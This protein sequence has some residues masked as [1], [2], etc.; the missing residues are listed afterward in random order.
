[1]ETEEEIIKAKELAVEYIK[2]LNQDLTFQNIDDEL[3]SS[4]LGQI[5]TTRANHF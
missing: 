4:S 1:L 2:W 5:L 3:N